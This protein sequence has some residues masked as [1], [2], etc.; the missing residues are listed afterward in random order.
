MHLKEVGGKYIEVE[1]SGSGDDGCIDDV[2][3]YNHLDQNVNYSS[4]AAIDDLIYECID[5]KAEFEGDWVNNNGGYGTLTIDLKDN[6]Y[7]LTVHFYTT[8]DCGWNNEPF[9]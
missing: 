2:Q 8:H 7:D 3:L 9:I 5:E 6:T 4:N 1:F